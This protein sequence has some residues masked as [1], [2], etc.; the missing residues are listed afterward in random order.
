MN[1]NSAMETFAVIATSIIAVAIITV[2]IKNASGT[3][4]VLSALGSS[5]STILKTAMGN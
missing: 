2:L 4:S 1:M 5:F 3:S